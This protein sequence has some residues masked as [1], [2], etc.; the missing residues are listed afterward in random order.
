MDLVTV[1]TLHMPAQDAPAGGGAEIGAEED[2][3]HLKRRRSLDRDRERQ[4]QRPEDIQ[5]A[6]GKSIPAGG[7]EGAC[8]AFTHDGP[9]GRSG[10]SVGSAELPKGWK[11]A[12]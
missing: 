12:K 1:A 7:A 9:G 3:R 6:L 10:Q 8:H 5:L 11:K 4:N 2:L